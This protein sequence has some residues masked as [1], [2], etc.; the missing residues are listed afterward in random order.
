MDQLRRNRGRPKAWDDKTQQNTI[1]SLDRAMAVLEHLSTVRSDPD[2]VGDGPRVN[3]RQRFTAF[4]RRLRHGVWLNSIPKARHGMSDRGIFDRSKI[5]ASHIGGPQSAPD[6]AD[7][8]G[9]NR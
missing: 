3:P 6:T 5:P 4:L 7:T 2:R 1:K 8:D 9:R